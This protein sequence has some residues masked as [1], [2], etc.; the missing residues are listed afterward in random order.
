MLQNVDIGL[1][2]KRIAQTARGRQAIQAL[3]K[4]ATI[5]RDNLLRILQWLYRWGF[6]TSD[7]LSNLLGRANKSH[8]RRLTKDGWLQSVSIKGYPT[9]YVLTPKGLAEIVYQS[10]D[11]IEYKESDPYRV[12]LPTLHHYLLAQAETLAAMRS[13]NYDGYLTERMYRSFINEDALPT[14]QVDVILL[15]QVESEFQKIAYEFT[16]VEIE[17]TPKW[18]AHLDQFICHIIDDIQNGRLHNF[19]CIS[20]STVVLERYETA[21]TPGKKIA[22]WQRNKV[23]RFTTTGEVLVIPQWISKHIDFRK[24]GSVEPYS[25]ELF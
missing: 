6:S 14:K 11:L 15:S 24:V 1:Q 8:A 19:L 12:H 25:S 22:R 7:I 10:N 4:P 16:G 13:G 20:N 17:L 2:K 9:Y 21:F 18:G 5:Q 3:G 23:G